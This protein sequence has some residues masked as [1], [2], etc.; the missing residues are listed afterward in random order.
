MSNLTTIVMK[1]VPISELMDTKTWRQTV[2][3]CYE[4]AIGGTDFSD[5]VCCDLS[6][7]PPGMAKARPLDMTD[8]M[9]ALRGI[10]K[11]VS[12]ADIQKYVDF[13]AN[14]K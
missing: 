7:L 10:T 6:K 3:G 8:L 9:L 11:T 12:R 14:A 5:C 13:C 2:D 1:Q 4:P